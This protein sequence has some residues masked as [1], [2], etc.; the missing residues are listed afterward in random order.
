MRAMSAYV[1]S[2]TRS[3]SYFL[4][5]LVLVLAVGVM[6]TSMNAADIADWAQRIF[7]ITFIVLYGLLVCATLFCWTR[8]RVCRGDTLSRQVWTEAG[9]HAGGGVG[10]L[11]L[12]F[13][14]LGISLG[15]G[16]LADQEL[17]PET[18]QE[19]IRGLT[20]HFSMAF[21]TT[22]VGLPTST[23]L[24]ALVSV[25]EARFAAAMPAT[26]AAGSNQ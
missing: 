4:G 13:T 5:L 21:M 11:A 12:T 24:R 15:I 10:I 3:L 20:G 23:A 16:D 8:M 17:T 14:L 1:D 9:L 19:V 25:S 22:V 18:V 26:V 2:G 7:G 6:A